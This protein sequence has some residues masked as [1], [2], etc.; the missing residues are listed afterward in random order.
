MGPA[1]LDSLC[2]ARSSSLAPPLR[3]SVAP[4]RRSAA[5][6]LRRP[7]AQKQVR[8]NLPQA[9]RGPGAGDFFGFTGFFPPPGT[10]LCGKATPR[11]GFS[12]ASLSSRQAT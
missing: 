7:R 9:R 10:G 5:P 3:R 8:L 2:Y 4:P 6:P 11:A 12:W 1:G